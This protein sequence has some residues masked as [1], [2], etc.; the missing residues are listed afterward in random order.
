[1]SYSISSFHFI[2]PSLSVP[3]QCLLSILASHRTIFTWQPIHLDT[4]MQDTKKRN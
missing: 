1:L 3:S 2:V 4:V